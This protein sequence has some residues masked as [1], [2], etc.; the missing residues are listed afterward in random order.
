MSFLTEVLSSAQKYDIQQLVDK[1]PK[2]C[3]E[4]ED[5]KK[6][7]AK[8][9]NGVYV[10]FQKQRKNVSLLS[11]SQ[12]L[13]AEFAQLTQITEELAKKELVSASETLC[14]TKADLEKTSAALH[15][16]N[17]L[18]TVHEALQKVKQL[19]MHKCYVE[20]M[21]ALMGIQNCL[22]AIPQEERVKAVDKMIAAVD[23]GKT[24]LLMEV[25]TA[26]SNNVTVGVDSDGR[27]VFKV[28]D[29]SG[30]AVARLLLVYE[31]YS[32]SI[33]PLDKVVSFL[34]NDVFV[35]IVDNAASVELTRTDDF[36]KLI[37]T[38]TEKECEANYLDT[39]NNIK[40]VLNFLNSHLNFPLEKHD[41]SL[42]YIGRDLR[43]NLAELLMK[44]CLQKTIPSTREGL[45]KFKEISQ[46][47]EELH[48][49]LVQAKIFT[50]DF[51][52]LLDYVKN[53]DTLFVNKKCQEYTSEALNLMK[54]YL[55]DMTEVGEPHDL[56]NPLGELPEG[57]FPK[58]AVSKSVIAL[59]QL[60]EKLLQECLSCNE[61][62]AQHIIHTIHNILNT[63]TTFVPKHHKKLLEVIPQQVALFHNNCHYMANKVK[64]FN[65]TY[66]SKLPPSLLANSASFGDLPFSLRTTGT[67]FLT[68]YVKQQINQI[69]T[70]LKDS[71][72]YS[73][74]TAEELPPEVE[75]A[76]RKCLRQQ[77][78]LKTVW[79]KVL[80]YHTYNQT[81]GTITN[82]LCSCLIDAVM[83]LEDIPTNLA[84]LLAEL[85]KVVVARA[86][87]LFTDPKETCLFVANWNK[88][89]E[90]IF[91][92]GAGLMDIDDRWAHGMGPL[93]LHF[94]PEEMRRLIR[95]LFQNTSRRASVLANI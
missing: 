2:V 72:L 15:I 88:L 37:V 53:V 21:E 89:N 93:A 48:E 3:E 66:K 52:E 28:L 68:S 94:Q 27:S 59:W 40:K 42:S 83:K 29:G 46:H 41:S 47:T 45:E 33:E 6:T 1:T 57:A 78:L 31:L 34:W 73:L 67:D 76:V 25:N 77:E 62:L 30:E 58:C 51:T 36:H 12:Q 63:Y 8:Y 95:A 69:E 16:T 61:T 13:S 39:F 4:V 80:P 17:Q 5:F 74:Q 91:V 18:I 32:D 20:A 49:Q 38:A 81:I 92:L 50:D 56:N 65:R 26:L 87:K 43:D 90:V 60:V 7:V 55:Q 64:E 44:N 19:R 10:E 54:Q 24:S 82:S 79:C 35:P 9:L 14:N 11:K 70:I 71:G 23:D 85:Y 86:V 84:E 75:K 22:E